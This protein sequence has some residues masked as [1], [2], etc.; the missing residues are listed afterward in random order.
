[1]LNFFDV[2]EP[3]FLPHVYVRAQDVMQ[4]DV[5][6]VPTT[7]TL[8]DVGELLRVHSIHAVPMLDDA[9]RAQGVITESSLARSFLQELQVRGLQRRPTRLGQITDTLGGRLVVGE[10]ATLVEGNILIGAMSPESMVGYISRG[11]LVI[12]GD[13]ENAQ[14]AALRCDI[15]C[16]IIT[17]NFAP[18]PYIRQLAGERGTAI[19]VAPHDTFSTA[20]LI[21]LSASALELLEK[22][23]LMVTPDT[24]VSEIEL[25][26]VESPAAICL[27][28]DT[29]GSLLGVLTKSDL[30]T[31]RR[32][33]VILVDHSERS[34]SVAGIEQ[35]EILE[36]VDH[37]RL[38]G[39]ETMEPLLAVIAPVGSTATLVLRRYHQ[40][41]LVPPREIAG[42]MVAAILS[43]TM[44]L[45]SPTTTPEDVAA[46][47]H[48]GK[49]LRDDPLAFGVRMYD[50]KFDIAA[51]SPEEIAAND[52]KTSV[53]GSTKI[54]IS[55]VEVGDAT[56]VLGRKSEILT[57]M[58][59]LQTRQGFDLLMLMV[60]DIMHEG[61]ELL[62]LGDTRMVEKAFGVSLRDHSTYLPGVL[63]RKK[64][65]IP[66]IARM[67]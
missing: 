34:L 32:R 25:A 40:L 27:V 12:L 56:R 14:E 10:P 60:T 33:R 48:L 64:Q 45:R 65:M 44:L 8:H 58:A 53:L 30:V 9:G 54:G 37:H 38:G 19:V 66:A 39:V 26:L 23:V 13:R 63:S 50:A 21:N 20:R 61:T 55:Q 15:S 67:A 11:D 6:S 59:E 35:A 24:L 7:C 3:D 29:D 2:D 31:K 51:L 16:L 18:S 46:V 42:L 28:N 49:V 1:M 57:A 4:T 36:I 62:A 47:E 41:G 43:D 17:G 52:L 5:I 22:D